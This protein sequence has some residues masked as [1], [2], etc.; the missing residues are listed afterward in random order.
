MADLAAAVRL[1]SDRE[2]R[3]H[4]AAEDVDATI[5]VLAAQLE[6]YDGLPT[7]VDELADCVM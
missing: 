2:H 3:G 4:R 1:Y 5:E 6:R 7:V